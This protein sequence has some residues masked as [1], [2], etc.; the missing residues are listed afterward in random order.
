VFPLSVGV[1]F[2]EP[3]SVGCST[4]DDDDCTTGPKGKSFSWAR[5]YWRRDFDSCGIELGIDVP[6]LWT[7]S[8]T[9]GHRRFYRG[10]PPIGLTIGGWVGRM[11]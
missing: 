5:L 1:H 11:R 10:M 8:D 9:N 3:F 7:E 4:D 6:L 2:K